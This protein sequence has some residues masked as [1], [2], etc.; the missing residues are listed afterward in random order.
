MVATL[1][2][3]G[4]V[5]VVPNALEGEVDLLDIGSWVLASLLADL[6]CVRIG[7]SITLSMSLPV[8]LAA[9]LLHPPVVTASIAFLGCLDLRELR[10]DS[11]IERILFNRS[12]IAVAAGGASYVMHLVGLSAL[13]WPVV[14]GL[15]ALGLIVDCSVNVAFVATSTVLSGRASWTATLK[16]L[17]GAEPWASV[18]LYASMCLI[19]PL[20]A[21]IYV[22]WGPVALL[23][24]TAILAPLRL[25]LARIERL[26]LAL[27]VVR[28]REAALLRAHRSAEVERQEE[29]LVLAGDLH[30]EVLPALFK[31]HLMGEVLKQDLASGRLLELDDDLPEL[32]EATK[33]AQLAVRLVVGDLR[34]KPSGTRGLLASIRSCADQQEG[35]GKPHFDLRL[36]K[37]GAD[38]RVEL[39]L[40]QVAKE[41]MVNAGK[42]SG[43]ARV[44]VEL[45]EWPIGWA[46]LVVVDNGSGFDPKEVDVESHFGLQLMRD[47]IE[48][49]GG[50][51]FISSVRDGGTT[52]TADIPVSANTLPGGRT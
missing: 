21:L 34:V 3:A 33:A 36:S 40:L 22:A 43:A 25:A 44:T 29:R 5:V 41:A 19:G 18:C 38:E 13:E 46:H 31:V 39:V 16:G 2:L 45:R 27:D 14:V 32:L 7:R 10:G 52:I 48:T 30:D 28:L 4:L 9:A 47:R 15:S 26:G 51:L 8:L 42:Y 35:D 49:V 37:V 20:L 23:L 12:Q 50:R 1:V 24:C 11:S 6:M 17:W